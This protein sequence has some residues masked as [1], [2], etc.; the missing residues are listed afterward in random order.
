M[1]V[2]LIALLSLVLVLQGEPIG[3]VLLLAT[4]LAV[5][6]IPEGLPIA[7]TVALAAA[8]KRMAARN[9]IVRSLPAVEGLGSCTLIASDKTGTLTQN[10]LSLER[11]LLADG[12][13]LTSSDW[14][15]S[16]DPHVVEFAEAVAYCNEV[17]LAPSGMLVGDSVDVALAGFARDAG[18]DLDG[19]RQASRLSD[20]PYEP[21]NR[22]SA[23]LLS[24]PGDATLYAKGAPEVVLPMCDSVP[25]QAGAMAEELARQG[26]RVLA[27]AAAQVSG[28]ELPD[29][30]KPRHL[31]LL[32]WTALLDP[33]RPEAVPR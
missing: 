8:T 3:R 10:Q 9:V 23:V 30:R 13:L 14:R 2:G 19:A 29:C 26:Y 17:S 32:G 4:A 25:W 20:L 18:V 7:V 27:V 22:F 21:A 31:R 24:R 1:A 12:R 16:A 11:V 15:R 5:S 28:N 6:A 33:L